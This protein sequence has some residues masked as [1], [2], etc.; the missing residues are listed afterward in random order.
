MGP[1]GLVLG[2]RSAVRELDDWLAVAGSGR[3]R[4]HPRAM[5]WP[6]RLYDAQRKRSTYLQDASFLR[7]MFTCRERDVAPQR[8][9]R[10]TRA[11]TRRMLLWAG[12]VGRRGLGGREP[13]L[14]E[15]TLCGRSKG[16][17][18][19]WAEVEWERT[20]RRRAVDMFWRGVRVWRNQIIGD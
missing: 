13:G 9:C 4:R 2:Q 15:R 19:S 5:R 12:R 10:I 11:G 20:R 16:V 18:V 14:N 17:V 6:R 3:Q 7:E 8:P 1:R